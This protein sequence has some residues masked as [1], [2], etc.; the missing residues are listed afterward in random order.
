M[1]DEPA[2]Y[3]DDYLDSRQSALD[4]ETVQGKA[5]FDIRIW[6]S[7]SSWSFNGME[8]GPADYEELH[9]RQGSMTERT[10]GMS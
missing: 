9:S 2:L 7:I 5:G 1:L 3:V 10:L 8:S 4:L 6:L